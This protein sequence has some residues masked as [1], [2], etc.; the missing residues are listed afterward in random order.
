MI[1]YANDD[2]YSADIKIEYLIPCQNKSHVI[3]KDYGLKIYIKDTLSW[4]IHLIGL[5]KWKTRKLN[6][7]TY[8]IAKSL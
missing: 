6:V 4:S 2:T 8:T 3:N 5:L 7:K 1:I